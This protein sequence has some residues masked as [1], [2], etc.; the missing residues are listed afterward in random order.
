MQVYQA[1]NNLK[2]SL[3][4]KIALALVNPHFLVIFFFFEGNMYIFPSKKHQQH[5]SS[6]SD[7]VLWMFSSYKPNLM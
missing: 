3:F 5:L 1:L 7:F 4:S 2:A 6:S